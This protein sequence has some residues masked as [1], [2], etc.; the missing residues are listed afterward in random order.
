MVD[1]ME[2]RFRRLREE[3][4]AAFF[5]GRNEWGWRRVVCRS[6]GSRMPDPEEFR[7]PEGYEPPCEHLALLG[8]KRGAVK[9]ANAALME[10]RGRSEWSQFNPEPT[11][12]PSGE[13]T[14]ERLLRGGSFR[15]TWDRQYDPNPWKYAVDEVPGRYVGDSRVRSCHRVYPFGPR[16]FVLRCHG[17]GPHGGGNYCSASVAYVMPPDQ[18][19]ELGVA[20]ATLFLLSSPVHFSG[21]YVNE[22]R[23]VGFDTC[24]CELGHADPWREIVRIGEEYGVPR[25]G[26][27][28]PSG[29]LFLSFSE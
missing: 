5:I 29:G 22:R 8:E 11:P 15:P 28:E 9:A 26:V 25:P 1:E 16:G 10:K 17:R 27:D 12:I 2:E 7:L 24:A 19:W 20:V 4:D 3:L 23:R 21:Q 13:Q 6:C 18:N 14:W